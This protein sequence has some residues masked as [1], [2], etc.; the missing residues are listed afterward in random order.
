MFDITVGHDGFGKYYPVIT[1]K[2]WWPFTVRKLWKLYGAP[3]W[4]KPFTLRFYPVRFKS[5]QL[6]EGFPEEGAQHY[7]ALVTLWE[8]G[9]A[10]HPDRTIVKT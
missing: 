6:P 7:F 3:V 10:E 8:M 5:C 2:L 1:I 4:E 9:L